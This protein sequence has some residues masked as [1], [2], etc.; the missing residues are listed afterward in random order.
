[1][2]KCK[3]HP[4]RFAHVRCKTCF[5]P[6]CD[7]C[8]I[9]TDIGVFCSEECQNKAKEFQDKSMAMIEQ[10]PKPK[11][12]IIKPVAGIIVIIILILAIALLLDWTGIVTLPF[13]DKL[14]ELIGLS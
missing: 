3:F 5:I 4:N 13:V 14:K 9:V 6:L 11:K 10:K 8:K 7:E 1:M 12:S 2:D